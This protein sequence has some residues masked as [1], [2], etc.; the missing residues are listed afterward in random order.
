MRE[1]KREGKWGN[2]RKKGKNVK[3]KDILENKIRDR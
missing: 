1:R 3:E 2:G